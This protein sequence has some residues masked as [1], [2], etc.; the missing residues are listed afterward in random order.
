MYSP[1][2][3]GQSSKQVSPCIDFYFTESWD[4]CFVYVRGLSSVTPRYLGLGVVELCYDVATVRCDIGPST[5][6][7]AVFHVGPTFPCTT[8]FTSYS[9]CHL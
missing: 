2:C 6:P 1:F 5:D 4:L 7:A 8:H 9:N 3:I